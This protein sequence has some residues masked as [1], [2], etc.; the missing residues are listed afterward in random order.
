MK[1]INILILILMVAASANAQKWKEGLKTTENPSF[2]EVQRT[3]NQYWSDKSD[4]QKS[5][6]GSGY[7]Q[8]K[9]F[10]WYW[11]PRVNKNGEF[12][13]NTVL[14][15]EWK[16]FSST[17]DNNARV[18]GV[19]ASTW[20]SLGPASISSGNGGVGRIN[21][22]AFH[23]T[24]I[25]TFWIGAPAGGLWKTT[26]GGITWTTNYDNQPI[27]GVSDIAIDPTNPNIM[28]LATGDGDA[29]I[30]LGTFGVRNSGDTQSVG[31]VKSTDGGNTWTNIYSANV[32]EGFLIRRI[33]IDPD[34]PSYLYAATSNGILVTDD[35][36]ATWSNQQSGYF[37]DIER[38]PT[39]DLIFYAS[40]F[41]TNAQVFVSTDG[42]FVWSQT[43]N[44]SGIS[45]INIEVS[46]AS[47]DVVGLLCTEEIDKGLEGIYTSTDMGQNWSKIFDGATQGNLLG[48]EIDYS[49]V[50]GQGTYDLAFAIDPTNINNLFVGGISTNKSSDG[51]STWEGSN[52]W[53]E[54]QDVNL[55]HADKHFLAYHPL[56]SSILF[57][58]ND[59][60]VWKTEDGGV[61]WI[62]LTD[63]LEIGQ[64]YDIDCSQTDMNMIV[65]GFQDNG[66]KLRSFSEW[67]E[68]SDGD[69]MAC[70]IDDQNG[71]VY[72]SYVEG[73]IYRDYWTDNWAVISENIPGGQPE[74]NWL[75]P[76]ELDPND[77]KI[78]YAGYDEVYKSVDSGDSWTQLTNFGFGVNFNY[79][80]V[81]PDNSNNIFV[82]DYEYIYKTTDGGSS[83]SDI[84]STLPTVS[85][86]ISRIVIGWG[87][88]L[89]VTLSGYDAANKVYLSTDLGTTWINI[90]ETGLP[91]VPVN[92]AVFDENSYE[93]YVGT[94]LGVFLYDNAIGT[95]NRFGEGMPN[96]VIT[97]LDIQYSGQKLRAASFGR[98]LWETDLNTNSDFQAPSI[99][100]LTPQNASSGIAVDASLDITFNEEIQ[101]GT[102]NITIKEV[103][104]QSIHELIDVT[105]NKVVV[106][107][108]SST[109]TPSTSFN[110]GTE[111]FV[112]IAAGAFKDLNN[113]DF[114][115]LNGSDLWNFL[116]ELLTANYEKQFVDNEMTLNYRDGKLKLMFNEN[117]T[118]PSDLYIY[119]IQ[120]KLVL[121][122]HNIEVINNEVILNKYFKKG[123]YIVLAISD[124]Q[125]YKEKFISVD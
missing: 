83:W 94:D 72:S 5:K 51:G 59:G 66:S 114:E 74:G 25:N 46:P 13:T 88:H 50:G 111:Y 10:E 98:G 82:G 117:L 44:F 69:G 64:F 36:G 84:T 37:M 67:S 103:S 65:G 22:I 87:N 19:E 115:G 30:S 76:Y 105:S 28:Y 34:F 41:G 93:L 123:L 54:S 45:R 79:L 14:Q 32:A 58:C 26:D 49:D 101:K 42:G 85:L 112:E 20:T 100:S 122:N 39:N 15:D 78:I 75:T 48:W 89:I 90:T 92:C 77:Q 80:A 3:F 124:K 6:K 52:Y 73:V 31:I 2:Y 63:G 23:P 102:G 120:G 91:N 27:L 57:E 35:G 40:T 109:I 11:A 7:K 62:N 107:G 33:I 106:S 113:I 104:N 43:T 125:I 17:T 18:Q 95:W 96:V 60:G 108:T 55:V 68:V 1:K 97:D 56:N 4:E 16:K 9:R 38:H 116:T 71:I 61:N 12:P 118:E 8:F 110:A 86:N 81:A 47:P 24:D 53:T 29:S 70:Q 21:C 121:L 119:D 99:I